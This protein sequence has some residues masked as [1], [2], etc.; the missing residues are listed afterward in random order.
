MNYKTWFSEDQPADVRACY[1]ILFGARRQMLNWGESKEKVWI[2][3]EDHIL[4]YGVDVVLICE[5]ET[6]EVKARM[7]DDWSRYFDGALEDI[8]YAANSSFTRSLESKAA[9]KGKSKGFVNG[10]G[11]D[12]KESGI[13]SGKGKKRN[14][15]VS[16]W[17]RF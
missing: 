2:D 15:S 8:I 5:V 4:Y 17:R 13:N 1:S 7:N 12:R 6:A 11:K 16:P 14:Q 10:K 3:K 9:K